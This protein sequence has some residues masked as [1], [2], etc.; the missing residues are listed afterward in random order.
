[1]VR[2]VVMPLGDEQFAAT[3]TAIG[4]PYFEAIK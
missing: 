3:L 1:V 4:M 2:R